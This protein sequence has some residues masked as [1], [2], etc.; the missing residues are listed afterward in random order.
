MY[1][2]VKILFYI[3]VIP[4]KHTLTK[5]MADILV[6]LSHLTK[7][8]R[9]PLFTLGVRTLWVSNLGAG[10][11]WQLREFTQEWRCGR[12]GGRGLTTLKDLSLIVSEIMNLRGHYVVQ[13]S[14]FASV[15][16]LYCLWQSSQPF[17]STSHLHL[18]PVRS[19]CNCSLILAVRQRISTFCRIT[20]Q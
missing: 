12:G 20:R 14:Q 4:T 2:C 1:L 18:S 13:T 9:W 17:R 6:I 15:L 11:F 7:F 16:S 10:C 3:L 19:F 8:Q 5:L